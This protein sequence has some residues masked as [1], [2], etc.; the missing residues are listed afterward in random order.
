MSVQQRS[1]SGSRSYVTPPLPPPR[2]QRQEMNPRI[3]DWLP[4]VN[5]DARQRP[6]RKMGARTRGTPRDDDVLSKVRARKTER[7]FIKPPKF[8][9]KDACVESHISQFEIIA[10]RNC[11]DAQ[12]KTDY[13]KCTLAGEANHILRDLPETASYEEVVARLRQRYGSLD[14][15]EACRVALK[16]RVRGSN[17]TL[18]H[19]MKDIRSLFLQAYPGQSS[20]M[21]EIMAR[22]AFVNALQDR[23]LILK[24][25]EREPQT[26]DQAFKIAERMELY[27]ALPCGPEGDLR[28][29]Q[30]PKVR[31]TSSADEQLIRSMLE[32]QK[33]MQKQIAT[34]TETL[35]KSVVGTETKATLNKEKFDP[36]KKTCF[37]CNKFG[38]IRPNCPELP[39]GMKSTKDG[40][41]A[42]ARSVSSRDSS[43]ESSKKYRKFHGTSKELTRAIPNVNSRAIPNVNSRAIP[44]VNSEAIPNVNSRA[45][46]NVN[47]R[48]IPNVN[49]RAI[50][51]VNSEAIPNVNS[52]AIPNVNSRA[53]PNVNSEAIPNVNSREI[54]NV[55]SESNSECQF[56]RQFRMLGTQEK[57]CISN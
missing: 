12:E 24:V 19:L 28:G 2:R 38:H 32:T 16:T 21:S 34:L 33:V 17:E 52:R 57:H 46:P 4:A 40:R 41:D 18:S 6:S 5:P 15:M 49:S 36:S 3:A 14:Q 51:N 37:L 54:P 47:S 27:K 11:W 45:I 48:A 22:D 31:Q 20:M 55:N 13:I 23:D 9:G 8:E 30:Q 10:R 25:M 39:K 35:Q 44:N 7:T 29:K 56:Q 1:D 53:I 26:L 50:P 43:V 42:V